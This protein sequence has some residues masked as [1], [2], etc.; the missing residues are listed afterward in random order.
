M[1]AVYA[2]ESST[3]STGGCIHILFGDAMKR[4]FQG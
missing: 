2:G 3:N 1:R 4:N